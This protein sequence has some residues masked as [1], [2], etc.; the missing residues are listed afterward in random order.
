VLAL[1]VAGTAAL[2]ASPVPPEPVARAW[3]WAAGGEYLGRDSVRLQEGAWDCGVAALAMVLDAHHRPADLEPVARE[4]EERQRG[5]TLLEMQGIATRRGV[6]ATGWRLDLAGLRRAAL[7]AI[8]HFDDHYV[9]VDRVAADGAVHFRDPALG[10]MVI[11]GERFT[12][13]WT[14][15]VLVFPAVPPR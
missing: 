7:P 11:P 12:R 15:H 8:A 9:V 3:A 14:G 4:V 6:N 1:L 13:L 10:Q 2:G 5:L